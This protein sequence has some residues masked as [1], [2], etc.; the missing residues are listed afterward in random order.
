M[1]GVVRIPG[2]EGVVLAYPETDPRTGEFTSLVAVMAQG[3]HS[4][5]VASRAAAALL[6]A[7]SE[8]GAPQQ[9]AAAM[10]ARALTTVEPLTALRGVTVS[11]AVALRRG[12]AI[13]VAYSGDL[14]VRCASSAECRWIV[15]GVKHGERVTATTYRPGPGDSV[16]VVSMG[17]LEEIA[18]PELLATVLSLGPH[19]AGERVSSR[20]AQSRVPHLFCAARFGVRAAPALQVARPGPSRRIPW[21]TVA[22]ALALCAVAGAGAF[23]AVRSFRPPVRVPAPP[24][25]VE[26]DTMALPQVEAGSPAPA[27]SLPA[28]QEDSVGAFQAPEAEPGSLQWRQR[29]GGSNFSSSPAV[30]WP[31]VY[32]GSKDSH[33]YCLLASTGEVLWKFPTGGG[34]GSSPAV[35]GTRLYF[36]SYDSTFYCLERHAGSCLWKYR[37]GAGIGASPVV[38]AGRVYCGCK[39]GRVYAWD[40]ITGALR[41]TLKTNAEVWARPLVVGDRLFVGSLDRTFY[42]VDARTGS[43][44]W[45][46]SVAGAVY[47]AAAQGPDSTVIFGV[48]ERSTDEGTIY[49]VRQR[50]GVVVWSQE[51]KP[52]YS[53][54]AVGNGMLFFGTRA[55]DFRCV[56]LSD[57]RTLWTYA[58]GADVR[59]SPVIAD[60]TVL[61]GSYDGRVYAFSLAGK[62]RWSFDTG[63]R[64]YSTPA[65]AVGRV[66]FGDMTGWLY[67][68]AK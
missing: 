63:S 47:T 33:L 48:S 51:F 26:P 18:P 61:I 43:P 42:C 56:G 22:I 6:E 15:P 29:I 46:I 45:T 38:E 8:A 64:I 39:D 21:R 62:L 66:Y 3:P 31:K 44:R 55:G 60:D 12:A 10:L 40:A 14:Q 24:L 25:P 7:V 20:L 37:T 58:T 32:V 27:E 1:I 59:S 11:L 17:V 30:V 36:G 57:H 41:W 35:D 9:T 16:V 34:I 2:Q 4:G 53:S 65:V 67:C 5:E 54:P 28:T 19:G 13:D 52:I 50:D 23:L 49:Q 68:L